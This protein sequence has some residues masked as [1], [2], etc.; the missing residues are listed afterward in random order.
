MG[1]IE[2]PQSTPFNLTALDR[3]LLAM[4]DEEFVA[5]DWHEL[6]DIIGE[7]L[8]PHL[9]PSPHTPPSNQPEMIWPHSSASPPICADT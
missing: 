9:Q 5:H 2:T 6:R 8:S 1:T 3:Q 4:T 7:I